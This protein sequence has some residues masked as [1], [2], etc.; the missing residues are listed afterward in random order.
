LGYNAVDSDNTDGNGHGTHVAGTIGSKT[1]GLAKGATLIAVKV[2]NAGGSG[3][4]AGVI[5]GINFVA[6][7][8]ISGNKKK[9]GARATANMSLGGG[10]STSM[11]AATNACVQNNVVMAVASG[12]DYN[13]ACNYSPASAEEAISVSASDNTDSMA[14]FSNW[15]SCV[16]VFG[17][18]LSITSTWINNPNADNT[19]SGTSMASPHVAGVA[20]KLIWE[21]PSFNAEKIKEDLL[22]TSSIN[23]L[24]GVRG[25]PNKLVYHGCIS[26]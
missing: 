23:K 15:G 8:A 9:E 22:A 16:D 20:T 7:D 25:S 19:I 13:D 6:N 21:N 10:K 14:Y 5:A 12:N 17:P 24:S 4:T 3:S 1:Y 18:G 2:L 26:R 11:N